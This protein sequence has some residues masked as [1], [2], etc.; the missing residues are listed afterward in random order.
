MRGALVTFAAI[1]AVVTVTAPAAAATF[2]VLTTTPVHSKLFR[3][4]VLV[5]MTY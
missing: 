1:V 4:P 5:Y 2:S 3:L